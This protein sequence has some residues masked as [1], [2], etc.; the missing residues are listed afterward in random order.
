MDHALDQT[1]SRMEDLQRALTSNDERMKSKES[2]MT[3][4]VPLTTLSL[5]PPEESHL[6]ATLVSIACTVNTSCELAGVPVITLH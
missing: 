5:M 3:T 4:V 6:R 1:W 2:T